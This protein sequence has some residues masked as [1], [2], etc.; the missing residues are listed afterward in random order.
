MNNFFL[1]GIDSRNSWFFFSSLVCGSF[2][3]CSGGLHTWH[4]HFQQNYYHFI[5]SVYFITCTIIVLHV[6]W[7]HVNLAFTDT[8]I[9]SCFFFCSLLLL[10][11]GVSHLMLLLFATLLNSLVFAMKCDHMANVNCC[12]YSNFN[13]HLIN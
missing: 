1:S 9:F 8:G 2:H 10:L 3:L 11:F 7:L 12:N 6:A 4:S 13:F 5:N